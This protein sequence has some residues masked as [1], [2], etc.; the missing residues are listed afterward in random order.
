MNNANIKQFLPHY[1]NINDDAL[2]RKLFTKQELHELKLEPQETIVKGELLQHQKLI[3]RIVSPYTKYNEMLL[4]YD[5][6]V[7]KTCSA[8]AI[9]E[10][11]MAVFNTKIIIV[12]RSELLAMSY[13]DEIINVCTSGKYANKKEVALKYTITTHDK[14][15]NLLHNNTSILDGTLL[16]IDEVHHIKAD[17]NL[18]N[19]LMPNLHRVR[20]FVM[21]TA[22]P[23]W[24]NVSELSTIINLLHKQQIAPSI[25]SLYNDTELTD[26]GRD[27]LVELLKG[28]VSY[29]RL[30]TPNIK[31][32]EMTNT[33]KS[34]GIKRWITNMSQQQY[35]DYVSKFSD[36][37]LYS[38]ARKTSD[39]SQPS[40][41][42][43]SNIALHSCKIA[44]ILNIMEQHQ[45]EVAYI[46]FD[47]I[48]Y[49]VTP[50]V[51]LMNELGYETIDTASLN[52]KHYKDAK[53]ELF[54]SPFK[55]L[56][57]ITGESA[58]ILQKSNAIKLFNNDINKYGE[59]I[60]AIVISPALSEGVS[61][62]N[63]RQFHL[64]SAQ[65]N[66]SSIKQ[67]RGR[68][69]RLN[70]HNYFNDDERY[71]NIYY[72]VARF[73][74]TPL[75]DDYMYDTVENKYDKTRQIIRLIK[76]VSIDCPLMYKRNVQASDTD[77]SIQC[78]YME[79]NYDCE[80]YQHDGVN[81][82]LYSYN[83]PVNDY[84]TYNL[85]YS[86]KERKRVLKE[87]LKYLR[88]NYIISVEQCR[89]Y[90]NAFLYEET[91]NRLVSDNVEITSPTNRRCYLG[92][93]DG[94]YYL[95]P[96]KENKNITDMLYIKLEPVIRV[97]NLTEQM[98]G[99]MYERNR[100]KI[101]EF[102]TTNT[103][104]ELFE[105]MYYFV[106]N[107]LI[108]LYIE[109][110]YMRT[111]SHTN[112]DELTTEQ[113]QLKQSYVTNSN[114]ASFIDNMQRVYDVLKLDQYVYYVTVD[115][116]G[117]AVESSIDDYNVLVYSTY[118]EYNRRTTE[119]NK[120]AIN[121]MQR[122][123]YIRMFDNGVW[124]DPSYTEREHLNKFINSGKKS[125]RQADNVSYEMR[126]KN[127]IV[128]SSIPTALHPNG[129]NIKSLKKPEL[130]AIIEHF[131][132]V[133]NATT[134]QQ[135]IEI[136]KNKLMHN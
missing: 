121:V 111:L 66:M 131:G 77:N 136:I 125:T 6:G 49:G 78:D 23:I 9:A 17:S 84:I 101:I 117:N 132:I 135:K 12:T 4:V 10:A 21:L 93:S 22:T 74:N 108:E 2:Q 75:I 92:Y 5:T 88:V 64:V 91:L 72:H 7:G 15:A 124:K 13:K 42:N 83:A 90:K 51:K 44:N 3:S 48:E 134:N 60:R 95:T 80:T 87:L 128:I 100:N 68:A 112:D 31:I 62:K 106:Q 47:F 133:T 37:D 73:N 38:G 53:R 30:A 63:I 104:I 105:S 69:I 14:F 89:D 25:E 110:L 58:T 1:P 50:F 43:T 45:N 119:Y 41:V 28:R 16:I 19:M 85:Y 34:T 96:Y 86:N 40:T 107:L 39:I 123:Y 109:R 81:D 59:F 130:D 46:Y 20:K 127:F 65:W 114:D 11:F 26:D 57:Y 70:S 94:Y 67:I 126:G 55:R 115:I 27:R 102:F 29:L 18:Y 113:I 122:S 71:I 82:G 103:P 8:I 97:N 120:G 61:L 129:I 35:N 79:C 32:N 54:T 118:L 52:K 56:L 36:H 76:E 33:D 24:D 98:F 116:N 99:M